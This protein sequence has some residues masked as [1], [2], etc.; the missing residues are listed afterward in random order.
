MRAM[1][2]AAVV[3]SAAFRRGVYGFG[4]LSGD[5]LPSAAEIGLFAALG[6]GERI[7]VNCLVR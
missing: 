1:T 6:A 3:L 4:K 2:A 7:A 5:A